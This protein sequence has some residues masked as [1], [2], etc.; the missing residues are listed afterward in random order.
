MYIN[1][2]AGLIPAL[3]LV[4]GAV[5]AEGAYVGARVGIMDADVSGLDSAT[6]MGVLLGYTFGD[7]SDGMTWAVEGEFT[8]TASKGDVD[9]A[10]FNG[11]WDIDTQAIY[12]V[13]RIGGDFYG[14]ARVGYLREDIS[15]S[16]A[17][18]SADGSDSGLSGGVGA[19][20]RIN[21]QI[22]IEA[23]YTLVEK[24][25]DFYSAGVNFAF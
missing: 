24:D 21:E 20:W 1:K 16:V 25:V 2:T 4:S 6:N 17:G 8:T 13:L 22:A 19:G 7:V 14:K 10:G 9:L 23:E 15:V 12:G 11:D 18:I 3:C 5:M